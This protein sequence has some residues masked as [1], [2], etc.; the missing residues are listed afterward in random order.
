M[1]EKKRQGERSKKK[2]KRVIFFLYRR[3]FSTFMTSLITSTFL[4]LQHS[5]LIY[6]HS[7]LKTSLQH[8]ML[9]SDIHIS[10]LIYDLHFFRIVM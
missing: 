4:Y 10:L 3:V 9:I 2:V 5:I 7:L 8:S 6:I 1:K